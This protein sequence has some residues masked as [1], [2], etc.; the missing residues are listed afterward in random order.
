M[1]TSFQ[2]LHTWRKLNVPSAKC[3]ALRWRPDS[4]THRNTTDKTSAGRPEIGMREFWADFGPLIS[5]KR[6]SIWFGRA[7]I[8]S[9]PGPSGLQLTR[10]LERVGDA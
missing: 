7:S 3:V 8:V 2:R 4:T 1:A 6:S 5:L 10:E 9:L